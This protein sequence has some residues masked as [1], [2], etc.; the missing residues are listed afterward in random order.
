MITVWWSNCKAISTSQFIMYTTIIHPI[1]KALALSL[2]EYCVLDSVYRLSKNTKY[3][4]WCVMS[5]KCMAEDL[6]ISERSVFEILAT[7]KEKALIEANDLGHI[8]TMDLWNELVAN[9]HDYYIGFKGKES[10]FISGKS[11]SANSAEGMQKVHS[12]YAN[13]AEGGMQKVHSTYA[14]SS[15]NNKKTYI[16]NNNKDIKYKSASR[17]QKVF[18]ED[19][20]EYRLSK[21]LLEKILAFNDRLK[22][23]DLQ[24]WSAEVDKMLRI[25]KRTLD[26]I[27]T[28]ILWVSQDSF[29]KGNILS[30][31]KLREKFDQLWSKACATQ[32]SKKRTH[33]ILN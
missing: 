17:P 28:L 32:Q 4:G 27:E 23:P 24:K 2:N 20:Q 9:D 10:Q 14:E 21:L 3:G 26:E 7:L 11:D 15:Y 31:A 8:R 19:S 33:L 12:G 18:S 13:S 1:R 5:K 29:W 16:I 6:D 22:I 30:T 25:D